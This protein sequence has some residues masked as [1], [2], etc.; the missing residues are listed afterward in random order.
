MPDRKVNEFSSIDFFKGGM[1]SIRDLN[2]KFQPNLVTDGD[3][4]QVM[5]PAWF[6]VV[7]WMGL[8]Q[9]TSPSFLMAGLLM[10]YFLSMSS[11]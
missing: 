4:G 11:A 6:F 1:E 9:A 10:W 5:A 7:E 8:I 3:I 2:L